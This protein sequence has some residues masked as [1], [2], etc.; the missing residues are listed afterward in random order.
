MMGNVIGEPRVSFCSGL[1][2]ALL[3]SAQLQL[4][5]KKTVH[6]SIDARV[7]GFG[8]YV[9]FLCVCAY[10]CAR[11]RVHACVQVYAHS[12]SSEESGS[13]PPW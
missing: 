3:E 6:S 13:L 2:I 11:A 5:K 7:G 10:V 1:F 8:F 9:L 12:W 4:K